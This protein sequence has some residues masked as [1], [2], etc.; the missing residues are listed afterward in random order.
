MKLPLL[1]F[2]A[3]LFCSTPNGGAETI[4]PARSKTV[5]GVSVLA[6]NNPFFV[7]MGDAMKSEAA[8]V[9]A[10]VLLT[11]ADSDVARQKTQVSKFIAQHVDAIVLCP[12][13]SK[14]IGP[15]IAEAHS[16]GIPIF[17][18]DI[19]AIAE[20]D[21]VICHIAT[22]NLGGGR[23][24]GRAMIE[25]LGGNGKVAILDHP[26]VESVMLRTKGFK[27]V[28]DEHN[29]SGKG[30][31]EIVA[32]LPC[33]GGN[34]LSFA[35]TTQ[36]LKDHPD[37]NGIFAI[38][39]PA[40]LGAVLALEQTGKLGQVKVVGFD[41]QPKGRQAI[42]EGKIWGDPVQFPDQIGRKTIQA[43]LKHLHG[44]QVPKSILIPTTFY[45]KANADNDSSLKQAHE[46]S[47]F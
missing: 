33:R 7:E 30:K 1:V 29:R 9:G 17:T 40:A 22:D 37:V 4:P 15:S 16:S 8:T 46:K 20:S 34:W 47:Q 21:K 28:I 39:D 19:A 38:N 14:A 41:A 23:E 5:I 2:T 44:E 36:L 10:V 45:S 43:V 27:E 11:S 35:L 12:A 6:T 18:A 13:D 3:A 24:A 26:E 42:K 31:I 32:V 25:A